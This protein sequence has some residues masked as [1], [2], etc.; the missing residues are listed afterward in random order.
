LKTK[1]NQKIPNTK[2]K[3]A[4]I[5]GQI[6]I[7]VLAIIVFSMTLLYGYRAVKYFSDQTEEVSNLQLEDEIKN[8]IENIKQDTMG[9]IKKKVLTV[10]GKYDDVC[11]I[12]SY[13]GYPSS[14]NTS[15]ALINGHINSGADDKNLFLVPPGDISI[16]VGNIEVDSDFE[17][18]PVR[19]GKITI[20]IESMGDH[21]KVSSWPTN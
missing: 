13:E 15:Y 18:I 1:K 5:S 2:I 11:F 16:Y 4:Q 9:T 14:L 7:Y 8:V 10:P 12:N 19:S 6:L 20:K 17:C 21:V 3:K